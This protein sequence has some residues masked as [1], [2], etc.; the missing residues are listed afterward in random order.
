MNIF[1]EYF[2]VEIIEYKDK[3]SSFLKELFLFFFRII[4]MWCICDFYVKF[5]CVI[6]LY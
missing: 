6:F 1:N 4:E 2:R 5:F 3:N